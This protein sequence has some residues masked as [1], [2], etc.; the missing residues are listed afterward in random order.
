LISRAICEELKISCTIQARR[1]DTLIDALNADQGDGSW[2]RSA[3]IRGRALRSIFR[4]ILSTPARFAALTTMLAEPDAR[5]L[6]RENRRRRGKSAHEAYLETFFPDTIRKP[7]DSQKALRDALA[8]GEIDTIFGDG[9]SPSLWL[10]G[11]EGRNCCG[12]RGGPF[13]DARF[14]GDGVGIAV[15]KQFAVAPDARLRARRTRRAGNLCRSLSQIFS[16]RI[17]LMASIFNRSG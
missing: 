1:F 6:A 16:A 4:A 7:Y 14:F 5:K 10:D 9:I 17:L 11:Q 3:S 13:I 15:K 12:F 2:R 8:K